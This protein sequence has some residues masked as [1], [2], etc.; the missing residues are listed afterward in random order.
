MPTA[1]FPKNFSWAF[2]PIH[3]VNVRTKFKVRSFTRFRDNRGYPKIGA[4]PGYA[5]T[6]GGRKGLEIVV[7]FERALVSS[8]RPSIVTFSSIFTRVRDIAV[9]VTQN[10]TFSLPHLV[11]TK[12]T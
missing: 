8:Y 1:T 9:F 6:R 2:V 3:S 5:H 12:F 7:P 4:V 11:S 10:A